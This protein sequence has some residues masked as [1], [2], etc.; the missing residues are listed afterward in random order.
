[1]GQGK[2]RSRAKHG[3]YMHAEWRQTPQE[4][5]GGLENIMPAL[6]NLL[7]SCSTLPASGMLKS[8]DGCMLCLENVVVKAGI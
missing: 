4:I 5:W 7:I 2:A 6:R 8:D 1:M 3:L